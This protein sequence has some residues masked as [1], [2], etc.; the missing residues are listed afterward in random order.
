M[1]FATSEIQAT[2]GLPDLDKELTVAETL[3]IHR[4]IPESSTV[5]FVVH[6][7]SPASTPSPDQ[8]HTAPLPEKEGTTVMLGTAL[9]PDSYDGL[10]KSANSIDTVVQF[11]PNHFG[12]ISYGGAALESSTRNLD[13]LPNR[14]RSKRHVETRLDV[15]DSMFVLRSVGQHR[16]GDIKQTSATA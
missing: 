11:V 8:E 13:P 5:E 15:P 2:A 1:N 14:Q 10:V 6:T 4:M 9:D 3:G 16:T 7:P 12:V